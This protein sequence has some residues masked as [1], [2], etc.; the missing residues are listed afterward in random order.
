MSRRQFIAVL[1]ANLD[2]EYIEG[3]FRGVEVKLVGGQ[4][5]Q[6]ADD[7]VRIE[8]EVSTTMG[9]VRRF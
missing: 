7:K 2:L 9:K 6:V 3:Q 5:L 8:T 4:T 1:D